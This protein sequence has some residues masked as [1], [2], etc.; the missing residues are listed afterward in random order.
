M[1]D[2]TF[3]KHTSCPQCG[4]RDNLGVYT[5]HEYCFGC[6]YHSFTSNS[7][8]TLPQDRGR[9]GGI[10][11]IVLP[12]D[13]DNHIP[14][15][16]LAWLNKYKLTPNEIY[17]NR[18]GWSENGILI[19]N[20]IIFAPCLIFPV[21][22]SYGNLLMW[23]GRYFGED[24]EVPKYYTRGGKDLLHILGRRNKGENGDEIVLTEDLISAIK[25]SRVTRA[26]P[27]FGSGI[28]QTLLT[29]LLSQTDSL[30]FWL[31]SDKEKEARRLL[32]RASQWFRNVKVIA[33]PLDPK[34]YS[35]EAIRRFLQ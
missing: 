20:S 6:G 2:S 24:R 9:H 26:M 25:V 21:Y 31:D 27:I 30:V 23:Q 8:R 1:V 13:Y 15:S 4:S 11:N 29:R 5:D 14:E 17:G 19:R 18:I 16:G 32:K 7:I 35:T 12:P 34:E 3:I 22:D 10:L 33:T 28:N